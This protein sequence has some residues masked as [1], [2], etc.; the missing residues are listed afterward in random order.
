MRGLMVEYRD[1]RRRPESVRCRPSDRF[2]RYRPGRGMAEMVAK[3]G[4][5][6]HGMR[7]ML[8]LQLPS[9]GR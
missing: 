1:G 5:W 4:V 2:D 8:P 6:M 7:R 3:Q 9:V